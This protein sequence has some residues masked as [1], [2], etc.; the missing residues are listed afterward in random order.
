MVAS[1]PTPTTRRPSVPHQ[2]SAK[3]LLAEVE[4][5][6]AR[7]TAGGDAIAAAWAGRIEDAGF[8]AAAHNLADYLTLR[9]TDLGALQAAL[10]AYGLSSLGRSEGH[11][12][13]QAARLRLLTTRQ[14]NRRSEFPIDCQEIGIRR[15][16]DL[17]ASTHDPLNRCCHNVGMKRPKEPI[18]LQIPIVA[19]GRVSN[20]LVGPEQS[21]KS[22]LERGTRRRVVGFV[23]YQSGQNSVLRQ[24]APQGL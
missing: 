16:Y 11:V 23:N 18:D 13:T 19:V 12:P 2:P 21:T 7:V 4:Q 22:R 5:L 9:Q 17:P 14:D 10:S 8:L 3:R 6:R 20:E 1:I 15:R 24:D